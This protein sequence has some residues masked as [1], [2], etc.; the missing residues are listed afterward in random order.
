MTHELFLA[1]EKNQV[2]SLTLWSQVTLEAAHLA[3]QA[4]EA[5]EAGWLLFL[6]EDGSDHWESARAWLW[7]QL[8]CFLTNR[9]ASGI[10]NHTKCFAYQ[11]L[12]VLILPPTHWI[13]VKA[14]ERLLMTGEKMHQG[15]HS[16]LVCKPPIFLICI[17]LPSILLFTKGNTHQ[18]TRQEKRQQSTSKSPSLLLVYSISTTIYFI[19]YLMWF[20]T[21][22]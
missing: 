18:D 14:W 10:V 8:S 22:A 3:P 16:Q 19:R 4:G 17:A 12:K 13:S 6:R 21:P 11:H 1:G 15:G 2:S 20:T 5:R 7:R 9:S